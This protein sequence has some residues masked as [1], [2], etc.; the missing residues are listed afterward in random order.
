MRSQ[1][2]PIEKLKNIGPKSAEWLREI[3][4]LTRGDLERNGAILTYKILQHRYKGI[5]ILMLYSLYGA[6]HDKHWNGLSPE[7]KSDLQAAAK[8]DIDISFG[9]V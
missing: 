3:G 8:E 4:V 1:D 6:L 7:E 2:T 9:G 5:N